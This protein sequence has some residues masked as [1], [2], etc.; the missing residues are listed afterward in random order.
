MAA[1]VGQVRFVSFRGGET[2]VCAEA[3]VAEVEEDIGLLMVDPK[4]P[5]IQVVS[6]TI[7][8]SRFRVGLLR[9]KV[10]AM[11]EQARG[12]VP[13]FS[14]GQMPDLEEILPQLEGTNE[15]TPCKR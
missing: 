10:S 11:Q 5:G 12:G 6:L 2:I 1:L 7:S 3:F 8:G 13:L 15:E 4:C 14:L 9:V